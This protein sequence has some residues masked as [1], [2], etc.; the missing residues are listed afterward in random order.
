[1]NEERQD[2]ICLYKIDNILQSYYDLKLQLI[3]REL[4]CCKDILSNYY[5]LA[6]A[7]VEKNRNYSC[8]FNV[9]NF[10]NITEPVHSYLISFLLDPN[11][12]HGQ[13]DLFLNLFLKSIDIDEPENGN[14]IVTA[15]KGRIDI[16]LKRFDPH[17]VVVIEN[18][19]NYAIDQENQ[20]YRYWFQE[21]FYPTRHEKNIYFAQKN[22]RR[23]QII[24]LTPD[25]EKFPSENTL[26]R[27]SSWGEW[28]FN[29]ITLPDKIPMEIK[30]KE[31]STDIVKWL[32]D[33]LKQIPKTNNRLREYIKQYIE[34][35]L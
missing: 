14:W 10:F 25:S 18:K 21:I 26:S 27:P 29:G 22:P 7:S 2:N 15:E 9:F 13:G 5:C 11:A 30:I 31:F 4:N 24:Y 20:L 12:S 8:N 6:Q 32:E 28:C 23:Y 16:L 33:S 3:D 35:W 19:S 34:L 1:M 17:S